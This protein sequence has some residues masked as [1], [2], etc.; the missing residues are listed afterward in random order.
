MRA[1]EK[2]Y[3]WFCEDFSEDEPAHVKLSARFANVDI[4]TEFKNLFEKAV[5]AHKSGATI[6]KEIKPAEVKKEIKKEAKEEVVIPSNNKENGFGEQFKLK[7]GTWECPGCY[8]KWKDEETQCITCGTNKDG[9]VGE[10][11]IFSKPSILQPAPGTPKV[12][13]G[14]GASAPAK[15]SP[16]PA[17]AAFG[18][19]LNGSPSTA[20]TSIF[21][22]GSTPKGSMFGGATTAAN[23][24]SPFSFNTA[25]SAAAPSSA[26][27]TFNFKTA[28]PATSS[29]GNALFGG[30]EKVDTGSTAPRFSFNKPSESSIPKPNFSFSN[31]P[32][33][34]KSE[35]E[36]KKEIDAP[37]GSFFGGFS[38]GNET[39]ASMAAKA[40]GA[41][42]SIFDTDKAEKARAELASQKK[43]SVF[44][45]KTSIPSASTA[46]K[47]EED[48][49][50]DG[51]YEPEVN[52]APVIPLPDLVEVR[53]GEE[54]EEVVFSARCKLYKYFADLQENKERGVGDIKVLKSNDNKYR[55]VMRR[56]QVHKICANF[57]IEKSMKLNP[58][59]NLP[60][61]LT[62][63][64]QDYSD[65]VQNPDPAIFTAKFKDESI[66]N[67][68]K[69]AVQDA[70]ATM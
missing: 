5:A 47:D 32:A 3:T 57:R 9:S 68:F 50:E 39:L 38:G 10:K 6:D 18:A 62:F 64:C 34:S 11:S 7:A 41:G 56:D 16:A 61:V 28:S 13:F 65:D 36:E 66:A 12:Q 15:E 51:E 58:K 35:T 70:Q 21:G 2:A 46:Q 43:T 54:D 22:G 40:K 52:F 45:S 31:P 27:P 37:K 48:E 59:G 63:M 69:K 29:Q 14:F 20:K 42:T 17:A 60:Q 33:S 44:G 26:K 55:I 4:A 25:Q 1:S 30:S 53:T 19:S 23:T 67:G 49:G 8:L 24:S